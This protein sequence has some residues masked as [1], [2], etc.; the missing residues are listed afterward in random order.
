MV[1]QGGP[2]R[3][4]QPQG[5]PVPAEGEGYGISLWNDR[6]KISG[7]LNAAKNV[8][9]QIPGLGD[10]FSE[11]TLAR[12]RAAQQAERIVESLLKSTAGSVREQERLRPVIGIIPSAVVG[13]DAYGTKLIALGSTLRSMINEY[14]DQGKENSGL[15]PAAKG[16]ARQRASAL[17][18]QLDNL[19]LPPIVMTQEE[20]DKYPPGTEVLWQGTTP[21]ARQNRVIG[22]R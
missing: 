20:L 18:Q 11:I 3:P 15:T 17:T 6:Y 4:T 5:A 22:G 16:L 12:Q 14:E 13:G 1:D 8:V 9:S 7:P 10:P 2:T 19:G 21:I